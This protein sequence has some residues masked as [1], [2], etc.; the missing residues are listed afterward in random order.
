MQ[1]YRSHF[2][3]LGRYGFSMKMDDLI[4]DINNVDW[5]A[6]PDHE[7]FCSKKVPIALIEL[8]LSKHVE[9]TE[10]SIDDKYELSPL[11]H[12]NVLDAIGNNHS[13]NYYP[14]AIAALPFIMTVALEGDNEFARNNAIRTLYDLY[15]FSP[16][17]EGSQY[18][19]NEVY[20]FIKNTI[21]NK[22][23]EFI[24]LAKI[25]NYNKKIIE[26]FVKSI[27]E[28]RES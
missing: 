26:D 12:R 27:R 25:D 11:A 3:A 1:L 14:V 17:V 20:R 8:A 6:F 10:T 4:R 13:G 19:L 23:A 21:A 15:W 16:I 2:C 9:T 28:D 22:E 24:N 7:Y 5:C 18:D